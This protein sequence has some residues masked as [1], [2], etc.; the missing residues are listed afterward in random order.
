M[1]VLR[2]YQV[3]D[4]IVTT[5]TAEPTHQGGWPQVPARPRHLC[6]VVQAGD[7][8]E[9]YEDMISMATNALHHADTMLAVTEQWSD[10]Y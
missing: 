7:G 4:E 6:Y 3:M 8:A 2:I 1:I 9:T 10:L 5:V